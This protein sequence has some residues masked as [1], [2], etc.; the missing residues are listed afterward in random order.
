MLGL[1]PPPKKK[2][3][4]EKKESASEIVMIGEHR[5]CQN[6]TDLSGKMPV[7][8]MVLGNIFLVLVFRPFMHLQA[9]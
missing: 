3:E 8:Q 4:K 5:S 9:K 6:Y 2:K 7:L 1:P